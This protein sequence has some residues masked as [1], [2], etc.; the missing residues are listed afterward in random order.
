MFTFTNNWVILFY[1]KHLG[2]GGAFLKE[3]S[4]RSSLLI[5]LNYS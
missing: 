2:D 5:D 4:R 3:Y 1:Q